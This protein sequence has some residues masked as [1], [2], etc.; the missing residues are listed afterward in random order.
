MQLIKNEWQLQPTFPALVK[1]NYKKEMEVASCFVNLI[2]RL[3]QV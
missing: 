3:K 2:S 1:K